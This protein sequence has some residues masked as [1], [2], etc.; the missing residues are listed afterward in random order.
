[1]K[2]YF[3]NQE[4][5]ISTN[6]RLREP[7][8][9][10]FQ[11]LQKRLK[12]REGQ[13]YGVILPVGCGKSGCITLTPFALKARRALVVAPGVKIAQQLLDDFHPSKPSCFY[14]KHEVLTGDTF[15]EPVEIRGKKSN[16]GDLEAAD[17]VITNIHQLQG[18][19][20]NRW[21][22][23]LPSDFFDLIIFDEGH[24]NVADSWTLLKEKFPS[25]TTVSYTAT[26]RRADGQCMTG[27]IIY[28][29]SV[30][31]AIEKGYVKR[32]KAVVLSPKTLKYVREDS[33]EIEVTLEEVK[34]LGEEDA[35]FRRSIVT[36]EE[37]LFTIVDASIREL[38][39]L[40][41]K[42][43]CS[44]LK[45]IASALNYEHCH[46]IV[47][48]YRER[49][50]KAN[51]IHSNETSEHNERV[52]QKLESDGLDV[53]VQVRKLGEG[54]NHPKLAVAAIFSVFSNLS[55]FV[56]FVGRV[57]RSIDSGDPESPLNQ[58]VVVFHAG[59]NVASR[60]EDFRDFSEADQKYFSELF[61]L[62]ES[63]VFNSNDEAEIEPHGSRP[64]QRVEIK[65][66]TS[67]YL[68]EVPL[69]RG[70][71]ETV[72]SW[73]EQGITLEDI[74]R[75]FQRIP[76]TKADRNSAR[77]KELDAQVQRTT[78]EILAR[79]KLSGWGHD[80]DKHRTGRSNFV[81]I[82]SA[83]D[84]AVNSLAEIGT[85]DR[86]NLKKDQLDRI[87]RDFQKIVGEVEAS[88]FN[89]SI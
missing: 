42:T 69:L 89:V 47:R 76:V 72:Q 17:V 10:S 50:Q 84:L 24:H 6:D 58:G 15:P 81:V 41:A 62:E 78:S 51:F 56:Q 53:I 48:A 43:G 18:G 33:P 16:L 8:K 23:K 46:Q 54:F 3:Q 27:E 86:H 29:Y 20:G 2:A 13:E 74:T 12:D 66:Q 67:M 61:P 21:L 73:A 34:R 65:E 55:P 49:A 75:E 52:L 22:G 77:I 68:E 1:M 64:S 80:L 88:V 71:R 9:G 19:A 30:A 82:K 59:S 79:H 11:E 14:F 25:A 4:P 31:S 37:T 63:I 85:K 60:W 39:R 57:M 36:S 5:H 87:D 35:Q 44:S 83:I 38:Q 7:Q 28:S 45:I 40:R 32:L 26:P 70:L